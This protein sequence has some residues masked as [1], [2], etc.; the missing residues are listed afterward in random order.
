MMHELA[1]SGAQEQIAVTITPERQQLIGV[2]GIGKTEHRTQVF[3][4]LESFLRFRPYP[5]G[6]GIGCDELRVLSFKLL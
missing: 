1:P 5:L 6:G 3:D 4:L 2:K